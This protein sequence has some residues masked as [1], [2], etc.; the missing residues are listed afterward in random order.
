MR[1]RALQPSNH[2][3][4]AAHPIRPTAMSLTRQLNPSL[5]LAGEWGRLGHGDS[6]D[7]LTPTRIEG[8]GETHSKA[9]PKLSAAFAA[10]AH[11]G[12]QIVGQR[13]RVAACPSLLPAL[14][15][16][17]LLDETPATCARACFPP[18]V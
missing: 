12:Y 11:S 6:S 7:C 10:D 4:P 17:L 2:I 18:D 8:G 9:L 14:F 1:P 15:P 13:T 16:S 3:N 5:L